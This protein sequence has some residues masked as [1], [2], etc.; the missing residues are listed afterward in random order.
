MIVR[1]KMPA[2]AKYEIEDTGK[3]KASTLLD[4][5]FEDKH[6]VKKKNNVVKSLDNMLYDGHAVEKA[7]YDMLT[8]E[9]E[10]H[11]YNQPYRVCPKC[12][13][14]YNDYPALSRKDNK[15]E[16]CPRCGV[17]EAM[18]YADKNAEAVLAKVEKRIEQLEHMYKGAKFSTRELSDE[19]SIFDWWTEEIGISR[20][21]D[22]RKFLKEAIKLGY[23]G[24][25]CFKVGMSGCANGMWA[26]KK[27]SIDGYSPDGGYLYKSFTPDY[28]YWSV[29]D[30]DKEYIPREKY[31]MLKNTKM[32]EA[33][34]KE[35]GLYE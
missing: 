5:V 1:M 33:F 15:T 21:K 22:M 12:G 4:I 25:V 6:V 26:H 2:T 27:Q 24:Y 20:L 17:K 32:L 7:Y 30:D 14:G 9:I 3:L 16:I 28:E 34:M 11:L 8:N 13:H 35:V 29:G 18:D 31:D 19:L 10:I 23:T